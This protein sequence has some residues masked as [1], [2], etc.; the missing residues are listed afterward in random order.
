MEIGET[1]EEAL[2]VAAIL[3][4]YTVLSMPNIDQGG[5]LFR[6]RMSASTV[7]VE[8]ETLEV[9]LF[10]QEDIPRDKLVFSL[11]AETLCVYVHNFQTDSFPLQLGPVLECYPSEGGAH[12]SVATSILIV[13]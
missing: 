10:K 4:P 3:L 13:E 6:G 8:A 5:M 11:V 2:A 9:E 12:R 1:T 7:G